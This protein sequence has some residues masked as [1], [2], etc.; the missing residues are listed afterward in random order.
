M[1]DTTT[2]NKPAETTETIW[3]QLRKPFP[4]GVIG[5]L[6]RVTCGGCKNSQAGVCPNHS[7]QQCTGCKNYMTT[8][9]LHLDFVGHA[10]VT[11]RLNTVAGPENWNWEP[12]ATDDMGMPKLDSKGNLWIKLTVNNVTRLGYGDGSQSMK[13]LIGDALRNAAMRFGIA[14]DL[15][16]KEE[17]E[18]TIADPGLKNE[19]ATTKA[20]DAAPASADTP[21]PARDAQKVSLSQ[22]KAMYAYM[23]GK[24]ITDSD[25]AR[26]ILHTL[27]GVTSMNDLTKDDASKLINDLANP[28][29]TKEDLETLLD[30]GES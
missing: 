18:S 9:H 12:L 28:D 26:Q 1:S 20:P 3:D 14:L 30:G 13:E 24:G 22:I 10:A 17:L 16:S 4:T 21:P 2:A 29:N 19:R 8:A 25:K 27:A 23:K 11:D 6:P 5:K 7:K 15:W